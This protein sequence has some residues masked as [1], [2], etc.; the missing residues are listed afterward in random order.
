MGRRSSD[1]GKRASADAPRPS[2]NELGERPSADAPRPSA[3]DLG[4]H[5]SADAP[6]PSANDL[7]ERSS[8]DAPRP[9][10]TT[11]A[12][13]RRLTRL[14]R[15]Q[16]TSANARRLMRLARPQTTSA[17]AR[18]LTPPSIHA[19]KVPRAPFTARGIFIYACFRRRPAR[20][21]KARAF[22]AACR[23]RRLL[24]HRRRIHGVHSALSA[25]ARLLLRERLPAL[26][27]RV[28]RHKERPLND[29]INPLLLIK[30]IILLFF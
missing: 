28:R 6:C 7:G 30:K 26:P 25:E 27:L 1:L 15:P 16:T 18:R 11:S 3:D 13:A 17:N 8:A 20:V 12:N 29:A 5:P 23:R 2:A 14:A 4:E 22:A 24:P 21:R 10:A 19:I 9:Y